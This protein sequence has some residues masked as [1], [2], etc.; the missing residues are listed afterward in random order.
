MLAFPI[1]TV[2]L[3]ASSA[4]AKHCINATVPVDV[5]A[6]TAVFDLPIPQSNSDA[7]AFIQNLAQQGRNFTD[8]A[9]TGYK[10]TAGTYKISTQ[11]CVP[12]VNNVSNPTLQILTHGLGFDK[13]YACFLLHRRHGC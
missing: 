3:L 2:A 7:T 1:T 9:L 6:R 12:S 13:T 8:V 4:A 11:F 5:S 10:T